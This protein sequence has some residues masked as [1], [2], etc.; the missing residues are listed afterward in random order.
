MTVR[1]LGMKDKNPKG[2]FFRFLTM[3]CIEAGESFPEMD[4]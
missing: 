3:L 4:D 1:I 2:H